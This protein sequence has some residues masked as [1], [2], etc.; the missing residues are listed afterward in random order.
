MRLLLSLVLAVG[1]FGQSSTIIRVLPST[2]GTPAVGELRWQE[3]FGNGQNYVAIKSADALAG[4]ITFT[5]PPTLPA[6]SGDCLKG[7]TSGVLSFGS[8]TGSGST[9][10]VTTG[11]DI[12][13]TAGLVGIGNSAPAH[14]LDVTGSAKVYSGSGSTDSVFNLGNADVASPG[15]GGIFEFK[16]SAATPYLAI[17]ALSQGVGWRNIAIANGGGSVCIG[18]TAPSFKLDV[19]GAL[20]ATGTAT[21]GSHILTTSPSAAD[22]GDATNYFQTLYVENID[23]APAGIANTYLRARKF[24]LFD[25]NG[26]AAA[27]WDQRVNATSVT[28]A[29][30]LRDNAGNRVMQ[31]VSQ[32]ASSAANFMRV[33]KELRPALRQTSSGDAVTDTTLPALGNTTDRWSGLW[34]AA[35]NISGNAVVSG[36]LTFTDGVMAGTLSPGLDGIGSIGASASVR[37]GV[38]WLYNLSAI[39]T[40]K[41]GASSTA[42]QVWTASGTDGT[43][44]WVTPTASVPTS[45]TIS[46]SS[47]LSGGGD[48]T[49]NRT[50]SCPTCFTTSGGTIT[51]AVGITGV[52]TLSGDLRFGADNTHAIGQTGTRPSVVFSRID[53]T[54]KLE[55]ADLSGGAFWDFRTLA[56]GGASSNALR[57]NAGSRAWQFVRQEASSAANYMRVFG[58]IRPAQRATADGDAVNDG[59]MPALG[60]TSA[61]WASAWADAATVTNALS[62]GSVTAGTITATTAFSGG[63]DGGTPIGSTSVRMGKIWGYDVDFAG[64]VKLGTSSTV[65]QVWTASDT[66]GNGG[67]STPV[68]SPWVVSGSDLYYNTGNVAIGDTTTSIARLL[69]RTS[70]VNVLAIHNSGTSSSTAGA[71]IQAAM[72]STPSSGHR[73][74]FYSFGSF[75]SGTRYN[76]ASV[77]AFTT[78]NWT[79]GSAQG[80]EL[81]LE[82]TANGA[83]ARTASV[84]ARASGAT[85]AGSLGI[86]TSTPAHALE[87]IGATAKVY[88][89]TNTA[90]TT[91]HIGN[92]DTGAPG[93]G[94][95]LAFVASAATP[96]FAINALSQGVAWRDIALANSGGS[97]CVGCIAPTT[98]LDVSGTFR[99]TGAATL[100]STLGVTGATTLSST[101]GVTGATTLSSTLGVTGAATLSGGAAVTGNLSFTGTLN[102]AISTTELGFLDGVTSSI[103]TQINARAVLSG[104]NSFSGNQVNSGTV[105]VNGGLSVG[106]NISFTNDV[107]YNLG[108]ATF[109]LAGIWY[110]SADQYGAHRVRNGANI[111]V[112]S[113]GSLFLDTGSTLQIEAG[114]SNGLCLKSDSLGNASWGSCA[115]GVTSIATSSPISGGTITSTGTISCPTCYTTSGG[116]VGGNITPGSDLT[117]NLGS[118][119]LKWANAHLDFIYVY[120]NLQ[121]PSGNLGASTTLSCGTGQAVK[122]IT[123][124]GGIVTGVTCGTP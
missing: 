84:V 90:D 51:G 52:T 98:K 16:A 58:E 10:W 7:S 33:F 55:I 96:Y 53:N 12:Y 101:L 87:V 31:A 108:S 83:A 76:G 121:A 43:G 77:T 124:S 93:Q 91:L 85:V 1:A 9:Q 32:E 24:E 64:T 56:S 5:L 54:A 11:S 97:V 39:G 17:N 67:W 75:V 106:S 28:S 68:T 88:S 95:F 48:L 8:C 71:G 73:L 6:T 104:G 46:T 114:A 89:G 15:Q 44:G 60:N 122:T 59:T 20:R 92:G 107:T 103:Q 79:L 38:A 42:G 100:G 25:I 34:A 49:A 21:I 2:S 23:A 109:R 78:E 47:P 35:A 70:N 19:S 99:A 111:E 80:T 82:T 116:S 40:V 22:I 41:L 30:T 110:A 112:Q 36:T 120:S 72:E 94:A 18:C 102:T 81:R 13:Y 118:S 4:N 119:S 113:G 14:R 86:N 37:Y 45:R 74:A 65:G 62:A 57:D 61:R 27:F 115:S 69:A 66:T 26:S 123:V 29:W 63:T 117:W 50:L 3:L 105:Q